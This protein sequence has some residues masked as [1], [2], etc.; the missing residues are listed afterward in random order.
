MTSILRRSRLVL[1]SRTRIYWA[2]VER[3]ALD[4]V[5]PDPSCVLDRVRKMSGA[6]ND[7]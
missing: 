4:M 1:T 3:I 5:R 6:D 7:G 2:T